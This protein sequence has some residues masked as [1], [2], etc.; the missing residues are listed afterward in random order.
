MRFGFFFISIFFSK[1]VT[2]YSMK[3]VYMSLGESADRK[4]GADGKREREKE[5]GKYNKIEW[6]EKCIY[7]FVSGSYVWIQVYHRMH[8]MAFY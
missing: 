2:V 3:H 5:R 1:W 6:K 7:T 4:Q 8:E